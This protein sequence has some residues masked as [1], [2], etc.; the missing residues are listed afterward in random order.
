MS[1][2]LISTKAYSLL[3][4]FNSPTNASF[5]FNTDGLHP[6]SCNPLDT[7]CNT[8]FDKFVFVSD[9]KLIIGN[10]NFST[11]GKMLCFFS[12]II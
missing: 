10:T 5:S 6:N 12:I 2:A 8:N 4:T 3:F 7:L 11:F 1:T 9:D